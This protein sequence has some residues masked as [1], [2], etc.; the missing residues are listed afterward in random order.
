[1]LRSW[2]YEV[3]VIAPLNRRFRRRLSAAGVPSRQAPEPSGT[4]LRARWADAR[5]L[6]ESLRAEA[7]ML[8]HAHGFRA[9]LGAILAARGLPRPVPVVCSPHFLPHLLRDD[10]RVGLRKQAYRWV[11][12]RADSVVV[13]TETQRAQLSAVDKAAPDRAEIVPY[14]ISRARPPD[15]M[16]LGRRRQLLG[17]TS[18]AAIVGCVADSTSFGRVVTFLDSAAHVCMEY[19]SLEFVLIGSD[20]DRGRY[21]D[22]AHERGLMGA[23]VFVD[24]GERFDA[25]I[26]ALNVL[27]APQ[28]GWPSGMLALQAL[29]HGVGVVAVEGGEVHEMLPDAAEVTIA[30][31]DG[32]DAL[33]AAIIRQLQAT[34]ERMEPSDEPVASPGGSPFLVST[35]FYDLSESWAT[36]TSGAR[37]DGGRHP[38]PT[39]AFDST[40][41]ARALIAVYHDLLEET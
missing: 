15:S 11:L 24:P 34:A 8:L 37:R 33:G 35:D 19:P 23:S 4:S 16:D 14:G 22:L 9:A 18:S 1:M 21:H 27:V 26:S 7:P 6:A 38:D 36:P 25:A 30:P 32:P 29:S 2:A 10:P 40:S 17:M 12:R 39:R 41:A 31:A 5:D 3:R 20:V 28:P 13:P